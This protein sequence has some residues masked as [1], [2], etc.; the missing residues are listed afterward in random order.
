MVAGFRMD[1]RLNAKL[2]LHEG[3]S[4]GSELIPLPLPLPLEL[5]AQPCDLRQLLL[6][7]VRTVQIANTK[8]AEMISGRAME[9]TAS[10]ALSNAG[11]QTY[12]GS[13]LTV[14]WVRSKPATAG[15]T[16]RPAPPVSGC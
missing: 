11:R 7:L 4:D 12:G 3:S 15:A 1:Y 9:V 13:R 14:R 6:A 16:A 5:L 8:G 10:L 2:S